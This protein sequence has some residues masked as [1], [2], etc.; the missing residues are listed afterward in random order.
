MK[1]IKIKSQEEFDKIKVVKADEEV[2]FESANIGINCILEVFGFLRLKGCIKSSWDN[3]YI[4]GRGSS[5]IHNVGW[6]S[7]QIHN[8]G[9]GSSQ[10]HNEGW[11]SSQIHNEGRGSSQIHNVGRDSSQIHNVGRGSSQIHNAGWG[12]S[13]IHNAG[14]CNSLSL[15]CFAVASIPF[16]LKIKIKKSKTA[17][18]QRYKP[19][20]CWFERNGVK[21]GKKIILYKKVSENFKTQENTANETLWVIGTT[22]THRNWNPTVEECGEGKFHACSKPYFCDEF[23]NKPGD[24]YV[25]ILANLSDIFEWK[26]RPQ[27]PHKIGFKKGKVLYE[28]NKYGDKIEEV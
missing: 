9:W 3:K 23:R 12:S 19:I 10:I 4:V 2:I 26:D 7:S 28:C 5:Q 6:G 21:K 27:Y 22:V 18:I 20:D 24:R 17:M 15:F 14:N 25:A 8:E 13:Q 16:D 11:G 1:T